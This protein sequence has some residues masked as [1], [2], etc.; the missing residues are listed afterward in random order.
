M[1]EKD[2]GNLVFNSL[3]ALEE[4][5]EAALLDMELDQQRVKSIT[6]WPWIIN[7]NLI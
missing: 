3:D 2:F 7:S 4:H 1:R 6:A 5:L